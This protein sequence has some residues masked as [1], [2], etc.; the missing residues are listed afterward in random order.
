MAGDQGDQ[1]NQ[2]SY[3]AIP[4]GDYGGIYIPT[5]TGSADN[6]DKPTIITQL[7]PDAND[8]GEKTQWDVTSLDAAITWLTAH[9]DYL[10]RMYH[11]MDELKSLMDGPQMSSSVMQNSGTNGQSGGP[12]GGFP[13]AVKL[14][15]RHTNLFQS[16]NTG[17]KTVVEN[18]YDAADALQKVKQK[19][20]DVEGA[21]A[22][23]AAEMESD[24]SDAQSQISSHNI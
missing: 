3:T 1:G 4:G 19:Y 11:G 10:K 2:Y 12:L 8:Q 21:N 7:Q 17:L 22:M 6:V 23:S 9:A 24:F 16:F 14:A 18:L 20:T 15:E 13:W 5:V